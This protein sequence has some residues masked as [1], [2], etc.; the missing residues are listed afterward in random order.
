MTDLSEIEHLTVE[1]EKKM[2]QVQEHM[3]TSYEIRMVRKSQYKTRMPKN[4][5]SNHFIELHNF[6]IFS[7]RIKTHFL[8]IFNTPNR[9]ELMKQ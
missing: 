2:Q 4:F 9:Y 5:Y 3:I 6:Q 8:I 7:L 1:K